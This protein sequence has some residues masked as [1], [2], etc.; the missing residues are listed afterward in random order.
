V[1]L[2]IADLATEGIVAERELVLPASPPAPER[3]APLLS[4]AIDVS[5][6]TGPAEPLSYGVGADLTL[7]PRRLPAWLRLGASLGAW[8]VPTQRPLRADRASLTGVAA[9]LFVGWGGQR[10]QAA[11][12]PF[13]LPYALDGDADIDRTGVLAGGSA[14]VRLAQP[15]GG[16][17]RLLAT[18]RV[19]AFAN[20]FR[21]SVGDASPSLASP[22]LAVALAVGR[23]WDLGL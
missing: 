2:A 18:L 11:I 22:R 10:V 5:K 17:M 14:M 16:A 6:G 12:G 19:D 7:A 3:A 1:A 4:A 21:V 23:G 15:I 8:M 9:R 13:A 20:R